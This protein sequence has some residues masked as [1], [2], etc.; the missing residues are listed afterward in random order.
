MIPVTARPNSTNVNVA[1]AVQNTMVA[2]GE[3][4]DLMGQ[5][6]TPPAY[7]ETDQ[8]WEF[9]GSSWLRPKRRAIS[10]GITRRSGVSAALSVMTVFIVHVASR[11]CSS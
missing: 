7:T 2:T 9:A 10:G 1:T 11:A 4:I 5:K 8:L 3:R 6:S